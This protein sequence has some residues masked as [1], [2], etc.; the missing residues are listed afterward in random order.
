MMLG[1]IRGERG[2]EEK[3]GLT[4]WILLSCLFSH[5]FAMVAG[6]RSLKFD[7]STGTQTKSH[8]ALG[9]CWFLHTVPV[10]L[11]SKVL[12]WTRTH[13]KKKTTKR[14]FNEL[15]CFCESCD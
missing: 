7:V 3:C 9:L 11:E 5:V 1:L 15:P 14:T 10:G 6:T 13:K 4:G 2:D 8:T 12:S